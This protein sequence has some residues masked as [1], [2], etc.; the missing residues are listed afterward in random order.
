[1]RTNPTTSSLIR[2]AC[3]QRHCTSWQAIVFYIA[4]TVV[5]ACYCGGDRLGIGCFSLGFVWGTNLQFIYSGVAIE[6]DWA[7]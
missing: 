4:A 3:Y 6:I 1:M 2:A 5:V 7:G